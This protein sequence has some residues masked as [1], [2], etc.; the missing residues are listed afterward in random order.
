MP[1]FSKKPD[2]AFR[3]GYDHSTFPFKSPLKE[4][5]YTIT[6]KDGQ[7]LKVSR[8]QYK[9]HLE[10]RGQKPFTGNPI[11]AKKFI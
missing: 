4:G 3:L 11:T 10:E 6:T 7:E 5:D 9:A 1:K 8:E 2:S